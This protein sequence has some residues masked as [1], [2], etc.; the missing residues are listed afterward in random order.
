[1]PNQN[2]VNND[3]MMVVV[4]LLLEMWMSVWKVLVGSIK[5]IP[6]RP[7]PVPVPVLG[8]CE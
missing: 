3:V 6:K 1:M 4:R 8:E 7:V 5:I 2:F